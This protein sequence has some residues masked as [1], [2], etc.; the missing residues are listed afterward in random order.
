MDGD[1]HMTGTPVDFDVD[2]LECVDNDIND[3]LGG[4]V[5]YL[6][7]VSKNCRVAACGTLKL[8]FTFRNLPGYQTGWLFPPKVFWKGAS[9]LDV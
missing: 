7:I 8:G 5:S 2:D 3:K 6:P 9:R 4:S 1:H